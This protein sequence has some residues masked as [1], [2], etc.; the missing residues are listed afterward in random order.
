[1]VMV[2]MLVILGVVAG[3]FLFIQ[4][5]HAP[6]AGTPYPTYY[7]TESQGSASAV[8]DTAS[9]DLDSDLGAG[10]NSY[11]DST[12][13]FSFLY[14][15]DFKLDESDPKHVRIY[16]QGTTQKG[17]TEMYDGVILV[18][19]VV[20]L[21]N[22]NLSSWVD[23]YIKNATADGTLEVTEGKKGFSIKN[24]P[25]FGF[26]MRGL[27]ESQYYVLE[28]DATSTQAVLITSLVAD[29]GNLGFQ[30]QVDDS[31]NTLQLLK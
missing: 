27:G 21:D 19:E 30:K 6:N 1:M 24:Y 29:P 4:R 13:T 31:L 20:S 10:G 17:Q 26:K 22:K 9:S 15:N 2:L 5:K 14:P 23:D 28:K 11:L 7:V 16:K 18:F 12:K 3:Y 25:G 8:P